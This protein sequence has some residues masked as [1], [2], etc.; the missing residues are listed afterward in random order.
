MSFDLVLT[1]SSRQLFLCCQRKY[2]F[3]YEDR[4]TPFE[5]RAY[6]SVGR[7]VHEALA[8]L[9]RGEPLER[10]VHNLRQTIKVERLK[11]RGIPTELET[12]VVPIE[13]MIL[14]WVDNQQYLKDIP[15]F[16][17][18]G[19]VAVEVPFEIQI[20][21]GKLAFAGR[22]D[23]IVQKKGL[24]VVEHKTTSSLDKR[25]I[26]RLPIDPQITGYVWAVRQLV[27][28][29]VKGVI[30]NVIRK[31][32][33]AKRTNE[34]I[35]QFMRRLTDDYKSPARRK[36]YYYQAKLYRTEDE[37]Q[38]FEDELRW[39]GQAILTARHSGVWIRNEQF[40]TY[41]GICPFLP[42]CTNGPK[43][44]VMAKYNVRKVYHQEL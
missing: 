43:P 16:E 21:K 3:F 31:P 24:W 26:E 25:Y 10:V 1:N 38:D 41:Y 44:G 9:L 42:L 2:K 7:I 29:S 5:E 35:V 17:W 12:A 36:F 27:T 40:C 8:D 13:P 4:L 34:S 37:V 22:I 39:V 28:V 18:D 19:D 32:S 23:G 20:V 14:G 33:I 6:F 15:L 11:W 30:Y